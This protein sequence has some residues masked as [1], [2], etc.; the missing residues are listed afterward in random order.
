ML[1]YSFW[2]IHETIVPMAW[3]NF[4]RAERRC[5]QYV[6]MPTWRT[7]GR[8]CSSPKC[9]RF[10]KSTARCRECPVIRASKSQGEML[11]AKTALMEQYQENFAEDFIDQKRRE[12]LAGNHAGK[13]G[14][15][16]EYFS[17]Q[18]TPLLARCI[19][20]AVCLFYS[21][22][23]AWDEHSVTTLRYLFVLSFIRMRFQLW[24]LAP[25]S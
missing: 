14:V 20:D 15:E 3:G 5:G 10:A 1:G 21:R 12:S 24:R 7:P 8:H 11:P 6:T 9:A 23:M 16:Y 18:R 22:K 13:S 25:W 2:W 19:S 17:P 4:L